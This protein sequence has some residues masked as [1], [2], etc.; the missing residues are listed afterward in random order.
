MDL[1]KIID[2]SKH[3]LKQTKENL[4]NLQKIKHEK[5]VFAIP[6]IE[7]EQWEEIIESIVHISSTSAVKSTLSIIAILILWYFLYSISSLLILFFISLFFAATLD[8]GVDYLEKFKVPRWI[9]VIFLF[10]IIVAFVILIFGSMVPIVIEQ[11][12]HLITTIKNWILNLINNFQA[13]VITIP[14]VWENVN[15]WILQ[16]IQS[17]N[18]ENIAKEIFNN[19]SWVSTQLQDFAKWSLVAVW[20][21]VWAWASVAW[22]VISFLMNLILVLFLTFFM[23]TDKENLN[24][25][26]RSLFPPKYSKYIE[27]KSHDIQ[28]QIGS[29]IRWQ[30]ILMVIMF[31][32][33]YIWL[34]AIW[35]W[36]EY[37]LTLALIMWIWE[38]LPYIWPIIFLVVSLPIALNISFFMVFKLLILYSVLQF[39]EWNILVPAVMKKAVWLSPIVILLVILIWFQFLWVIW[40]IIAVPVSTAIWIFIKDYISFQA[41]KN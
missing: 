9:W 19:F 12:S 34:N 2:K 14:Y 3:L 29:W 17:I 11:I 5:K 8:T 31:A 1:H 21:A 38:F 28:H 39:L 18:V 22:N 41:K 16:T 24:S 37:G 27:S 6:E 26:F 25:F 7:R 20:G 32:I 30:L 13:W 10:I 35:M 4:K 36:K 23:V 15:N 33:S 40:A